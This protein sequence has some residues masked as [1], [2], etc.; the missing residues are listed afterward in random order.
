M[1]CIHCDDLLPQQLVMLAPE[2]VLEYKTNNIEYK[3]YNMAFSNDEM[4]FTTK[5][6]Y[7]EISKDK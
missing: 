7:V 5:R 6:M 4:T 2:C 1:I 3:V